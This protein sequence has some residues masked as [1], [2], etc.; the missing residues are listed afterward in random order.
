MWEWIVFI[1]ALFIIFYQYY[2]FFLWLQI[3]MGIITIVAIINDIITTVVVAI[4]I[5]SFLLL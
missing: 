2:I 3:L 5:S 4:G 1:Q